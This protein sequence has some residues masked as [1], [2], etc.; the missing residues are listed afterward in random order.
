MPIPCSK[1]Q[2]FISLACFV[3]LPHRH[4]F[5]FVYSRTPQSCTSWIFH[6]NLKC[7]LPEE[8]LTLRT[9]ADAVA[10]H[11]HYIAI[12]TRAESTKRNAVC[13]HNTTSDEKWIR[14]GAQKSCRWVIVK[15][16]NKQTI[17]D[18]PKKERHNQS[19]LNKRGVDLGVLLSTLQKKTF[20]EPKLCLPQNS[21]P[22]FGKLF[23]DLWKRFCFKLCRYLFIVVSDIS[24]LFIIFWWYNKNKKRR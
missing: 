4:G 8:F 24:R 14:E 17:R 19:S 11:C 23:N 1:H 3:L 9:V 22:L 10:A 12:D 13:I 18:T 5:H 16:S 20:F 21:S 7:M 15:C 2:K 6:A